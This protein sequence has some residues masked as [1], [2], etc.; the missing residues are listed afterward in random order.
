MNLYP[1]QIDALKRTEGFD[2]CAYYLDMGLGKT[3]IGS[4]KMM[5]YGTKINLI[6]CQK[7]KVQDWKEHFMKYYPLNY[8][9][10]LTDKKSFEMFIKDFKNGF[11][12]P[13]IAIINYDL[14]Y[15]RQELLKLSDFTLMLDES[16]MIK[17]KSAKRTKFI[18]KMKPSHIILLSGT[19]SSG[20]Y[21]NMWTQAHLL[22]WNISEKL[23]Q[24]HYINFKKINMGGTYINAVDMSNPYKNE[25]RLKSKLREYGAIYMK[26]EDVLELPQQTFIKVKCETTKEY[27]KFTRNDYVCLKDGTEL[28]G[29]TQ[30]NKRLY[31]RML[32]SYYNPNKF[33]AL[34]DLLDSTRD[35]VVI[36][37]QFNNELNSVKILCEKKNR[38]ISEINGNIKD[39]SNYDKFNNSVTC[40]QYQSGAMGLN[41]QKANKIIYLTLPDG[42]SDLFEQSKKRIH[43]IG[44]TKPC[45]YYLLICENS[46]EEEIYERLLQRKTYDDYLFEEGD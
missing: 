28:V 40:V 7:S 3:F 2:N 27:R 21:E 46:I 4:E 29:D 31:Q 22:G 30:F 44:Q 32:C 17:N 14:I 8:I 11:Y 33:Q 41:L 9:Y 25:E 37:Y 26:T 16:S 18:L 12:Y 6:V 38:P 43:R 5:H 39:L 24:S 42:S 20:K 1:H 15:R 36:F 10:N 45:F 35:R 13:M 23:Y 34:E 19:P